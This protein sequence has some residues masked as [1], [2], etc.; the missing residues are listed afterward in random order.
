LMK[1]AN[2]IKITD[3]S[4]PIYEGMPVYPGTTPTTIK[5]VK[6]GT[7]TSMLSEMTI[8]SHMG[9]HIDAPRHIEED[10]PS[11][12]EIPID[13]YY[14]PV[15]VLDMSSSSQSVK[16]DELKL[17]N[18]KRGERI[19][20]KTQNSS[21]GFEKFYDDYIYLSSEG[22]KYL[23]DTGVILVGIDALS[24]KKRGDLDNSSHSH[25]LSKTIPIIE[26]LDLSRALEGDYILAAFPL[27]MNS[28]GAPLRAVLIEEIVN[29][30]PSSQE[31]LK[32][33]KLYTD[34]GS[35]GNP[36]PSA[37]AYVICKMDDNV[38]EK[39]GKY[40]G[41]ITNNQAEYQGLV[42]GLERAIELNINHLNVFMDSELIVKQVNGL[43][44]V[45]NVDLIPFHQ[46]VLGLAKNFDKVT[47]TH[48]PREMNKIADL[49]VNRILD[50]NKNK[51]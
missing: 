33:A 31:S 29:Q 27:K 51:G 16:V 46:I 19:L 26:G 2:K 49:E 9:S 45:K 3:I 10:G 8:S 36:G 44:K 17:K 50:E 24:V 5:F 40:L 12:G 43:Y 38:V 41:E 7:G 1:E 37:S 11:L 18:I 25:L 32:E 47:F 30:K 48:I 34:G 22:A 13:Y 23:A 21:R 6:S 4:L 39:S 15:R 20:L 35:R 28:D 42:G 14:G